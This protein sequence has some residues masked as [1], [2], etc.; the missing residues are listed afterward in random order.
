[1]GA[2]VLYIITCIV[3]TQKV[4]VHQFSATFDIDIGLIASSDEAD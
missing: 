3:A 4:I 2:E 1:M